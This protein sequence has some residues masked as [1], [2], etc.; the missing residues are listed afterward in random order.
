M[1]LLFPLSHDIWSCSKLTSLSKYYELESFQWL[2]LNPNTT[3]HFLIQSLEGPRD[4]SL[5][6]IL[7]SFL[8]LVMVTC[9]YAKY[10]SMT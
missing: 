10:M 6:L 5:K 9:L 3:M 4:I 2:T 7:L 1:Y 8:R